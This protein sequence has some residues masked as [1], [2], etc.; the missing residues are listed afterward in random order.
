ME[1][2]LKRTALRDL[3]LIGL[4]IFSASEVRAQ[5]TNYG[6]PDETLPGFKANDVLLSGE[7]D[8]VSAFS[9]D[10]GIVIPLGPSYKV[11]KDFQ[12]QLKAFD[13]L[14]LWNLRDGTEC[15]VNLPPDDPL[16]GVTRAF[17]G[18]LSTVGAG[19][20]LSPG[21]VTNDDQIATN[22]TY[23]YVS[24][25]GGHH[26]AL[27]NGV[28]ID[29]SRLKIACNGNPW[30]LCTV[31]FPDGTKQTFT[32]PMPVDV[33]L[34]NP[35]DFT[36]GNVSQAL[37]LTT[38]ADAWGRTLVT[39]AYGTNGAP[40][41]GASQISLAGGSTAIELYWTTVT[42]NG[43]S[44]PAANWIS[45]PMINSSPAQ[46][47]YFTYLSTGTLYT[48]GITRT[49]AD[50]SLSNSPCPCLA[51]QPWPEQQD[52]STAN[53]HV[54]SGITIYNGPQAGANQAAAFQMTYSTGLANSGALMSLTLPTGGVVSYTFGV[55]QHI[56]SGTG[57]WPDTTI[58]NTDPMGFPAPPP[59]GMCPGTHNFVADALGNSVAITSR[60]FTEPVRGL[61]ST[62]TYSR[63]D[64]VSPN[65]PGGTGYTSGYDTRI[66]EVVEPKDATTSKMTRYLFSLIDPG[67]SDPTLSG[68]EM[69]HTVHDGSTI[70]ATT[71]RTD[72]QCS[73]FGSAQG[74]CGYL[75]T[76]GG[77]VNR[78]FSSN[79]HPAG[80]VLWYGAKPNVAD[81]S[82]GTCSTAATT[83][84]VSEIS[85]PASG[86]GQSSGFHYSVTTTL[87]ANVK[88]D[89]GGAADVDRVVTT[90]WAD[91]SLTNPCTMNNWLLDTYTQRVT[92]D[93]TGTAPLSVTSNFTWENPG[94]SSC[95]PF[96]TR[97]TT[98]D[99]TY[100]TMNVVAT[101]DG[102]GNPH[103]ISRQGVN[104]SL[105]VI[106]CTP[107]PASGTCGNFTDT[108]FF[109]N[110]LALNQTR[111]G[112]SY[113][114]FDVDRD[115][116]TGLITASRD[117]NSLQTGYTYDGLGR[118]TQVQPAGGASAAASQYCY[119]LA[120]DGS[121][122]N[123]SHL[124]FVFEKQGST[125]SC[126]SNDSSALTFNAYQYDGAGRVIREYKLL[127]NDLGHISQWAIRD[128]RFD[129]AGN[130][131]FI[132]EWTPCMPSNSGLI[133]VGYCAIGLSSNAPSSGT[134][135]TGFD[136]FGRPS[137][138]NA[139]TKADNTTTTISY[140]DGST[141]ASDLFESVTVNSVGGS[142]ATTVTRKDAFGR[143]VSVTEP[144]VGTADVTT[145][146]YNV[147][148]KLASVNQGVQNRSFVY[149]QFGLLR[150]EK[151]PEKG[152]SGNGTTSYNTYDALGDV[153]LK[154]D[155]T[156][157]YT[158]SYDPL[159]R[160]WTEYGGGNE[161]LANC[162]DGTTY[163]MGAT[164]G[165]PPPPD[166]GRSN[167]SGGSYP[168]GRLTRRYAN[169]FD[170]NTTPVTV[171]P[172]INDDLT[173]SG[174]GGRISGKSTTVFGT[175]FGNPV[176][177]SGWIYN[178]LGLIQEY[179]HPS[180]ASQAIA[181][182][183]MYSF[184]LPTKVTETVSGGAVRD[185]ASSVLYN[186]S[187]GLASWTAPDGEV[188]AITQDSTFLPR[189]SLITAGTQ[190]NSGTYMYDGAGNITKIGSN[191]YGYDGRSRLI[192]WSG[193]TGNYIYDRYGNYYA[194]NFSIN[195]ATNRFT[196]YSGSAVTYD[197]FGL[198]NVASVP[199]GFDAFNYDQLSRE[200]AYDPGTPLNEQFLYDGS[201]ERIVRMEPQNVG[202]N[203][204]VH[205]SPDM[206]AASPPGS[207][208]VRFGSTSTALKPIQSG[209]I[210]T[211]SNSLSSI[212]VNPSTV[213]GGTNSTGTATLVSNVSSGV[214]TVQLSSSN[215]AVATV[216]QSVNVTAGHKTA[217]FTVTTFSVT[218][219]TQVTISGTY[220]GTKTAIL[221]VNP[222]S[223]GPTVQSVTLNPT[224]VTGGSPSTGTVTLTQAAPTGG[225]SVALSS[226]NA[227][228]T[229]PTSV[230]VAQG[231]TQANF[232]VTTTA[233]SSTTT[234][235]IKASY[236]STFQS[237]PLTINP[238]SGGATVQSV[239]LNPTS[240]TGGSP[241]TGTVTL[242]Q[243]APTGGA[244]VALSS[245]NAAAT[246]PPSVTVPQGATQAT[247]TATTTTVSGTTIANIKASYNS[248]SQ[249]AALTINPT[250]PYPYWYLSFRDDGDRLAA[251]YSVTS[252][253]IVPTMDFFYLGNLVV[254]TLDGNNFAYFQF[255]DNLGS[256]RL[257][258]G[259]A[260]EVHDYDP[261]G[262]STQQVGIIP[263]RFAG[264]ERDGSTSGKDYD[265]ARFRSNYMGRFLGMDKAG[266]RPEDPQSWNRYSYAGNNPLSYVDPN[267][268][269]QFPSGG[270]AEYAAAAAYLA[271][272]PS[273]AAVLSAVSSYDN[274]PSELTVAAN[275]SLD[276][277]ATDAY[278]YEKNTILWNPNAM[279]NVS[280]AEGASGAN[281]GWYQTAALV[282]LHELQH[283]LDYRQNP[284]KFMVDK[285]PGNDPQY[286]NQE[287]RAAT[288]V[289]TKVA[290]D[291]GE[292]TRRRH[293][294]KLEHSRGPLSFV[295]PSPSERALM[296][297]TTSADCG[298]SSDAPT[299]C[300][301]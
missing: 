274:S 284:G 112:V 29:N 111:T 118:L 74:F 271:Q 195:T 34:G 171:L 65:W 128:T 31:N 50:N 223:G 176:A 8:N 135:F 141:L 250:N 287:E 152:A 237:A 163:S 73:D 239:T 199:A 272:S 269:V 154:A 217:T 276:L 266:G 142:P 18:G 205:H 6:Q 89:L 126:S 109:Q 215:T 143:V 191:V 158:L 121:V 62:T 157:S 38:V 258:K 10:T 212:T 221:T 39:V 5:E 270:S 88:D 224:S 273:G 32:Q 225:A 85:S 230:T 101:D 242:T 198:G 177:T 229:V 24:P 43:S 240:V 185:F 96:M 9:G 20:T 209:S 243:A 81:Q 233:V 92:T 94:T 214:A 151:N 130:K 86:W 288:A 234:A 245:D 277:N 257:V 21:Y 292:A 150:S 207:G 25:D 55:A 184:G 170:P 263:V 36:L 133:N 115:V 210:A 64:R 148:D 144:V 107:P 145:Y 106:S 197:P 300:S 289:E 71:V 122:S 286:E 248:S 187:A 105:N 183:T 77:S 149:D 192:S 193:Q 3:L 47:V 194:A 127:P 204:P 293:L 285:R 208:S 56:A 252:S 156:V 299:P 119:L 279:L 166:P 76:N 95:R 216:P 139:I 261:W 244:S 30:T 172:S 23:I 54:L 178:S 213:V 180:L 16:K 98:A 280:K 255:T 87:S 35:T 228:A 136:V 298:T 48:N 140:T 103:T 226:D 17:V 53:V 246:V 153:L 241:S 42:I 159:G 37:G 168:L 99:S 218:T 167:F 290:K 137:G 125:S 182:T 147:L 11:G 61:V 202:N 57:T 66:V 67:L 19:W 174:L 52:P 4:A 78:F 28:T 201:N 51:G 278:R 301:Q 79:A 236:N 129:L 93:S 102:S 249:S 114:S 26:P 2:T 108:L 13:T 84:C 291:L 82:G 219:S 232:T 295:A 189:P 265:H 283:F 14:K 124:N 80:H 46:T 134:H 294:G 281:T 44:W 262:G 123:P 1:A 116:S 222:S 60:M 296:G 41:W 231:A 110:S 155:G 131:T 165:C 91:S 75:T 40:S 282:L 27:S 117:P 162:Y 203:G 190:F 227:A 256:V 68:V 259:S 59:A 100:G 260:T 169:N 175:P 132:S 33:D 188:E 69:E 253:G 206:L 45:F 12:F 254:G 83:Q 235:N 211:M 297:N 160:L 113:K 164:S 58:E 49:P 22:Y 173:Y 181:Q 146:S 120:T 247:F 179:D 97:A 267:G 72:I 138:T 90:T 70:S 63:I 196:T 161:Y 238:A 7:Y 200:I 220:N 275:D 186:P 264:M 15:P 104:G 268:L 251:Q